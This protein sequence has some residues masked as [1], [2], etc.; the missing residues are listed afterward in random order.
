[1]AAVPR[2]DDRDADNRVL[3]QRVEELA[4]QMLALKT[5]DRSVSRR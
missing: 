5:I 2:R 3:K 4:Q 1:M